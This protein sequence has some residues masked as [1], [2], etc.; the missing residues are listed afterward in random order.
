MNVIEEIK[1][2]LR[3]Y[4]YNH[5]EANEHSISIFPDSDNGFIVHFVVS[6][7]KYTVFF[8]GWHEDFLD[9]QEALKCFAFGLSRECRLK[10]Y[11]RGNFAYKWTV[12]SNID[13]EWLEESSTGLLIFPFWKKAEIRYFQNRLT[14]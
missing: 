10:E 2:K 14:S 7:N 5:Y 1:D 3:K 11:R 8:N 13:G 9:K 6:G 12:E 4:S